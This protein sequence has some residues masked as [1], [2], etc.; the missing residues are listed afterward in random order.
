M[1]TLQNYMYFQKKKK[2]IH[3]LQQSRAASIKHR[4]MLPI[5]DLELISSE[6]SVLP[7]FRYAYVITNLSIAPHGSETILNKYR[8]ERV[9][10]GSNILPSLC[11]M[12]VIRVRLIW[13]ILLA[14]QSYSAIVDPSTE[15]L[16]KLKVKWPFS[17][18]YLI[19]TVQG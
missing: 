7:E 11:N 13:Q 12:V 3:V 4:A 15:F 2:N 8:A 19:H 6:V 9:L 14:W 5:A 10:L 18:M 16:M 1:P 17:H